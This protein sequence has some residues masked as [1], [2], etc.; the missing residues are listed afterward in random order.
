M[1]LHRRYLC[2]SL[3]CAAHSV[4][5]AAQPDP[6]WEKVVQ[7]YKATDNYA[8]KEIRQ[9]VTLEKDQETRHSIIR[10]QLSGWKDTTPQ[11]EVVSIEP[12]P[13]EKK[14]PMNMDAML[15]DAYQQVF[16]T[17]MQPKRSDNVRLG[18]QNATLFELDEGTLQ[19]V[20]LQLWAE[21]ATGKIL[22]LKLQASMPM[23][24][25]ASI[26]TSYRPGPDG[27]S[28]PA[29]RKTAFEIHIPFKKAKGSFD[30]T[31]SQWEARPASAGNTAKPASP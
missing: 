14:K 17:A 26:S 24:F 23:A 28:F 9:N 18:E 12:A 20:S 2:L 19:K 7:Q 6:L 16:S 13:K 31:L 22:Q 11:Y 21:P 25:E 3:L 15:K 1:N 29:Q 30:E 5:L 8:A 4:T 10:L 27:M